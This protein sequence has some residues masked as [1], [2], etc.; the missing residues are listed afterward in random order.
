MDP[1]KSIIQFKK[2]SENKLLPD[3]FRRQGELVVQNK[4]QPNDAD[5]DHTHFNLFEVHIR[6]INKYWLAR[7]NFYLCRKKRDE[8]IDWYVSCN[9]KTLGIQIFRCCSWWNA[10][11]WVTYGN[12]HEELVNKFYLRVKI[13]LSTEQLRW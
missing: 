13:S 10:T 1:Y 12:T 3:L 8:T 9:R 11:L 7:H 4:H 2:W 6:P 5:T